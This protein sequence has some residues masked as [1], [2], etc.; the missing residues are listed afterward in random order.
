MRAVSHALDCLV[1]VSPRKPFCQLGGH[2]PEPIIRP[3]GG[4]E[5]QDQPTNLNVRDVCNLLEQTG[6]FLRLG[7]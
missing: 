1:V 2:C 7:G 4:T 3:R 5:H 6:M